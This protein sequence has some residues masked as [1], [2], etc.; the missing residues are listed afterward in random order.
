MGPRG[1]V[2]RS[3]TNQ[4]HEKRGDNPQ[5]QR[6]SRLPES[7]GRKEKKINDNDNNNSGSSNDVNDDNNSDYNNNDGNSNNYDN[8]AAA[9]E[10]QFLTL[11]AQCD[12]QVSRVDKL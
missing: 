11:S 2:T 9:L 4:D 1:S 3:E 5:K 7:L 6:E 8:N 10:C 12:L